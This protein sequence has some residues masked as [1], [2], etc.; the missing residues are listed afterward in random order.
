M[1]GSPLYM[2]PEIL[3][4]NEYDSLADIWSLGV[5]FYQMIYGYFPY[6][7]NNM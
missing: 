4:S 6:Q 7:A 3:A 5:I 2:A 1:L